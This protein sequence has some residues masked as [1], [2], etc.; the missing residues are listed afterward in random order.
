MIE[1]IAKLKE[2]NE[3]LKARVS[4]LNE[5][6]LGIRDIVEKSEHSILL[7]V[8]IQDKRPGKAIRIYTKNGKGIGSAQMILSDSRLLEN[9]PDLFDAR[10]YITYSASINIKEILYANKK[11]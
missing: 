6:I 8:D 5:A 4:M 7:N 3:Q 9:Q 10:G 2:E 11:V 1:E